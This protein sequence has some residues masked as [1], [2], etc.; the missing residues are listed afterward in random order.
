MTWWDEILE[1]WRTEHRRSTAYLRHCRRHGHTTSRP[2][3]RCQV[4]QAL[5]TGRRW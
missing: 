5:E 2:S 3:E 1:D 4:C